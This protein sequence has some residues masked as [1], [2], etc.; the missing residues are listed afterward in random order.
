MVLII[1]M[2][3][4]KE[5]KKTIILIFIVLFICKLNAQNN[6]NSCSYSLSGTYSGQV[7]NNNDSLFNYQIAVNLNNQNV[8]KIH[9][10][11]G[12]TPGGSDVLHLTIKIGEGNIMNPGITYHQVGE[13]V[14][15]NTGTLSVFTYFEIKVE[16]TQ[17]H[18]SSALEQKQ[19]N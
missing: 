7:L 1:N 11:A 2:L 9:L 13:K 10:K 18:I 4:K 5:M 19:E 6:I 16:D 15:I 12:T 8:S 3:T 14:F 17:N